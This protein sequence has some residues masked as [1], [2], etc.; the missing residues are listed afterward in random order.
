M[1]TPGTGATRYQTNCNN[2]WQPSSKNCVQDWSI[3][4]LSERKQFSIV[5]SQW[6]SWQPCYKQNISSPNTL[7]LKINWI[8]FKSVKIYGLFIFNVFQATLCSLFQATRLLSIYIME[9]LLVTVAGHFS[10]ANNLITLFETFWEI[11]IPDSIVHQSPFSLDLLQVLS[12][13]V[14]FEHFISSD[15]WMGLNLTSFNLISLS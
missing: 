2:S 8:A 3:Q 12:Q 9:A 11:S 5:R 15:G 1:I 6:S 13:Q 4:N 7:V 14:F 10:G